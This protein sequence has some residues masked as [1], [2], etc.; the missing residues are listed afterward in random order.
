M[1]VSRADEAFFRGLIDGEPPVES[2]D[3][4]TRLKNAYNT[5]KEELVD[6]V[7][8]GTES[9]RDKL[10]AL[11]RL[12]EI[13]TNKCIVIHIVSQSHQ[14]AY[15]LFAVLNDRGRSL[16]DGDLLRAKTLELLEHDS[17]AQSRVEDLWDGILDG[18]PED[19]EKF[20][21]AYFPSI[22]GRRAASKD[23]YDSYQNEFIEG[24]SILEIERFVGHLSSSKPSFDKIRQGTWPFEGSESWHS[25]RLFRL[26]TILRH[27]AAHPL[28]LSAYDLGENKFAQIVSM[29]E[30]FVFRYITIVRA[31]PGPIYVP[32]YSE[33]KAIRDDV[34][35][36]SISTLKG[37][38]SGLLNSRANDTLF[39]SNLLAKLEYSDNNARNR[40]IRHFLSTLDSYNSW[41][42]RGAAGSPTP[43]VMTVYKVKDTTLEH[44]YPQNPDPAK[45]VDL[46]LSDVTNSLGNLAVMA[47]GDNSAAGNDD[48]AAKKIE[49][50]ASSLS[51]TRAL[52]DHADWTYNEYEDRVN[53]LVTM[54]KAIFRM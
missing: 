28:L 6:S 45:W 44:V 13:I 25:D 40:E 5:I 18:K 33:A 11:S 35:R 26:I 34:T 54:A 2:R 53:E 21:K 9:D 29:I 46:A 31:H 10:N 30:R 41:Y 32:Y 50:N 20:L 19:I 23:L 52:N 49:Y 3:S 15:R 38:L 51:I 27:E 7:L 37:K 22:T 24:K 43:E 36:Y 47:A 1:V 16:T 8:L 12:Y 4:H 39:E 48:F 17:A 14:E 42:R